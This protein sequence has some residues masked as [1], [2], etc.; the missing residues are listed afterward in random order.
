MKNIHQFLHLTFVVI[1]AL[2]TLT[3]C[4]NKPVPITQALDNPE[5][6]IKNFRAALGLPDLPLELKGAD[7][8]IN[9]PGGDLDVL[10]FT[11]SDGRKFYVEPHS[12]TV[13]EMDA[14][15]LLAS[16]PANAPVF[17]QVEIKER[18]NKML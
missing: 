16:I 11:D 1:T 13:V 10:L 5:T 14:R 15:D 9:S 6:A 12:I 2:G 3:A 7:T 8:M 18:V 17:S 4:T